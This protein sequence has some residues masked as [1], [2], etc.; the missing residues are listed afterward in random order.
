MTMRRS[1]LA[2]VGAGALAGALAPAAAAETILAGPPNQYFT[3]APSADQGEEITFQNLDLVDHDVVADGRGPDGQPLFRSALVARGGSAVVAGTEFLATGSYPFFCSIHPSMKGTLAITSAGQPKPRPGAG[4]PAPAPA[5]AP[6]GADTTGP[7]VRLRI[8]D[9]RL[10]TVRRRRAVRVRVT[11]DEPITIGLT[12]RSGSRTLG[13]STVRLTSPG[14]RTVT[15]RLRRRAS[16]RL[17]IDAHAADAAGNASHVQ[18][19][20]RLR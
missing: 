13:G 1:A 20:R 10:R 14:T 6:A 12:I 15:V 9:T 19:S 7:A 4:A 18:T 17:R 3:S 8:A 5:P 11:T 2:L 16:S